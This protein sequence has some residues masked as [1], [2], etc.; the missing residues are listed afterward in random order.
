MHEQTNPG[1][2][3]H[4]MDAELTPILDESDAALDRKYVTYQRRPLRL[5][6][7]YCV[8][9]LP[10]FLYGWVGPWSAAHWSPYLCCA[11]GVPGLVLHSY[12]LLRWVRGGY[13]A[14]AGLASCI[15]VHRC[16]NCVYYWVCAPDYPA[17]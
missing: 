17:G 4:N 14:R 11:L 12:A 15:V 2:A 7:R 13:S 8:V 6:G 3:G 1:V 5:V 9:S 16:Y 10:L